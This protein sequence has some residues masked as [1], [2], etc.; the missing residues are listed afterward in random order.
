MVV[1]DKNFSGRVKELIRDRGGQDQLAQLSGISQQ[2]ISAWSR[3]A[4]DPTLST[5]SKFAQALG[6]SPAWLAFGVGKVS[7]KGNGR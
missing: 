1:R 6:V 5:L 3:G 7:K 4:Q 2:T